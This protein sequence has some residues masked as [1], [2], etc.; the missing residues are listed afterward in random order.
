MDGVRGRGSGW[1]SDAQRGR[2]LLWPGSLRY[3][4]TLRSEVTGVSA[5]RERVC[6]RV[7]SVLPHFLSKGH[8]KCVTRSSPQ[9]CPAG[10]G[11]PSLR[12]GPAQ[13]L[14]ADWW[15]PG[16]HPMWRETPILRSGGSYSE[17]V[18]GG[19]SASALPPRPRL[20]SWFG[21]VAALQ[22]ESCHSCHDQPGWTYSL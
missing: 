7:P 19:A 17:P 22:G 20:A 9:P 8:G 16:P 2:L 11:E 12:R 1:A 4:P 10:H 6:G 13:P 18:A 3:C 15:L 5:S 14:A 21:F